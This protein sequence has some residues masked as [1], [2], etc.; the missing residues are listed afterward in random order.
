MS[1][2]SSR[3]SSENSRTSPDRLWL[4]SDDPYLYEQLRLALEGTEWEVRVVTVDA[5]IRTDDDAEASA[6]V[7][8][9]PASALVDDAVS[10]PSELPRF[11]PLLVTGSPAWLD[12]LDG[13]RFDD[14]LCEPW[15]ASEL[16][17]RLR[18]MA[19]A[20]RLAC[21]AGTVTWGPYWISGTGR[22]EQQRTAQQ[23]TAPLT[24]VQY[25]ILEIL[26][27]SGDEPVARETLAAVTGVAAGRSRAVDMQLSRLRA[28]LRSVTA[29]WDSPPA[30]RAYRGHGYR[31]EMS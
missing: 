1:T 28:R 25:A 27:R 2:K 30:I 5:A 15:S 22:D 8:L 26:A 7:L 31:L 14:Y 29:A 18:R 6:S 23:R 3:R 12:A 13:I 19:G 24:P 21:P 11:L 17:F 4:K 9:V 10:P 16:R 20:R